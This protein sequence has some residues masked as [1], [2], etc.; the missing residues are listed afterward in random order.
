MNILRRKS[1]AHFP[2]RLSVVVLHR[3]VAF[4]P[5]EHVYAPGVTPSHCDVQRSVALEVPGVG[6]HVS[7]L[8]EQLD[9]VVVAVDGCEAD[10][11]VA[12]EVVDCVDVPVE[13]CEDVLHE[14]NVASPHRAEHGRREPTTAA[15]LWYAS[16]VLFYR[17]VRVADRGIQVVLCARRL[18]WMAPRGI[19]ALQEAQAIAGIL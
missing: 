5:Y 15:V 3:L 1:A 16:L 2:G 18:V 7:L 13:P 11:G 12:S 17:K 9:H 19:A 14:A 8:N 10:Q 6:I 4:V